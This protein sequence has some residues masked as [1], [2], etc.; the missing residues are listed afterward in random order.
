MYVESEKT[1]DTIICTSMEP[2]SNWF[3]KEQQ[4]A[5]KPTESF[6]DWEPWQCKIK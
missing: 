3:N 4:L 6:H 5:K 2:L 1:L